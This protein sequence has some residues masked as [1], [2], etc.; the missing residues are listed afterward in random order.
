[1]K[2]IRNSYHRDYE[3]GLKGQD[4]V[5]LREENKFL[6]YEE[7]QQVLKALLVDFLDGEVDPNSVYAK[8]K[9]VV[10]K[11][12]QLQRFLVLLF[13]TSLPPSRALEIR[14]LHRSGSLA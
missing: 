5:Q 8:S 7:I 3:K 11:A 2:T 14:S 4:W 1:M 10:E 13:Y 9:S 12:K 6:H